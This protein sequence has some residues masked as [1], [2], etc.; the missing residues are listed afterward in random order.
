MMTT[1][2]QQAL[3]LHQTG[4]LDEAELA[5]RAVLQAEP[6][7]FNALHLLGVL[8]HQQGQTAEAVELIRAALLLDG[9]VAD[10]HGNLGNALRA[11]GR[12]GEA[13]ASY[14]AALALVPDQAELHFGF[15]HVLRGLG[16]YDEAVAH[17]QH[18]S[19]LRPDLPEAAIQLCNDL[20]GQ[21]QVE[22]AERLLG[23][24]VARSPGDAGAWINLA[25]LE[26][27]AGRFGE[28]LDGYRK[29]QVAAPDLALA[30]YNEALVLLLTGDLARGWE[31]YEWRWRVPGFVTAPP[32]LFRPR[33]TGAALGTSTLLLHSEQGFG[34][35]IQFCRYASLAAERA[36]VVLS[37]QKPLKRLLAGLAGVASVID[38]D[39]AA[40]A[41]EQHC[42]LLSL[43]HVFGTTIGTIPAP[44][45]YLAAEPTLVAAWARRLPPARCRIGIAWQGNPQASFDRARSVP[46][47][48]FK[49]LAE[50]PGV[51]LISLQK[52]GEIGSNEAELPVT[53]LGPDLDGG[54]DAFVDTA[55][56]MMSLDLIIAP[57]TAVAHLAGALGRPAW[58]AL[59]RVPTWRWLLDRDDS[60]WYPSLRLFRQR[61]AGDWAEVFQRMAAALPDFIAAQPKT[62]PA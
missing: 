62:R 11:L 61:E 51:A 35:T 38:P 57:D 46:L 3:A 52:G 5:Y 23:A 27:Q 48:C 17:Y 20:A 21:G 9:R 25:I 4:R 18:A 30:H 49:A 44:I 8:R 15:G 16:R 36:R 31:K 14:R 47:D 13:E 7:N 12:L 33:W 34:D 10:A 29:A 60:P 2:L 19:R 6:R 53:S 1:A 55:A 42:P 37:V 28:A 41:F 58:L 43:P 56:V 59:S 26:Q 32:R 40:P 24:M 50:L 22:A 54:P 45:P 39:A